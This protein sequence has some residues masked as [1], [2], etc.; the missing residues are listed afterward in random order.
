[1][2]TFSNEI[3]FFKYH[4]SIKRKQ[5]FLREM[6]GKIQYIL[7]WENIDESSRNKISAI[8]LLPEVFIL[9]FYILCIVCD[10]YMYIFIQKWYK[11]LHT[12]LSF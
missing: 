5:D 4:F 3:L 8:F 6:T 7:L 10:V 12:L 1:M 11:I 9:S 2:R